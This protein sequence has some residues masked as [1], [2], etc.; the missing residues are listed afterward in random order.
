[1]KYK[2]SKFVKWA[3]IL[4]DLGRIYTRKINIQKK[5]ISFGDFEGASIFSS[6]EVLNKTNLTLDE[7][8][9]I[10]KII[11]YQYTAIDHVKHNSPKIDILL[12]KFKYEE[13]VLK[14]LAEYVRCDLLGRKIDKNIINLYNPIKMQ[15]FINNT[16]N[17]KQNS[18][19]MNNTKNSVNILV[20]PPCSKKSTWV[21]NYNKNAIII[22]RDSC[23]E[24]IG[25]KYNKCNFDDAR[26][27]MKEDKEIKEEVDNL[28]KE[29]CIYAINSKDRDIIIDNPNLYFK[30]RKKWIDALKTTHTIKITIFLSS[31][32]E[33]IKCNKKRGEE[34]N[35]RITQKVLLNKLS[36][37]SY[38]LL[39]EGIDYITYEI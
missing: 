31:L 6:I 5:R 38:P 1:M 25:N 17:L 29:N 18:K 9:K 11:S 35:K 20:G 22:S 39:N 32:N 2:C 15:N 21:N 30:N 10:Y 23:I 26:K 27:F 19:N 33:L 8:V 24:Q 36:T 37:F 28:D 34:I 13:D 3:V 16:K 14:E 12:N 4:H 7:K